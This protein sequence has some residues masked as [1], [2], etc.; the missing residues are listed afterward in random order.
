MG[1]NYYVWVD[2]NDTTPDGIE[3]EKLHI[4]KSSMGWVFSLRIYK[5]RGILSL[6]D[7]LPIILN[8]QNVI[9]DEYGRNITAAE[10]L[11]TITVRGRDDAP[12]WSVNECYDKH[13]RKRI[14]KLRKATKLLLEYYGG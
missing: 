6:Y 8:N 14:A 13:E 5:D 7:W 1:T 9:R 10:M 12:N 4:G 3:C 2:T 11:S